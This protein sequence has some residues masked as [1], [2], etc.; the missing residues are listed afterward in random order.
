MAKRSI[1]RDFY[2][3]YAAAVGY[4]V[5]R[6]EPTLALDCMD[7]DG[8]TLADLVRARVDR[9]DLGVIRKAWHKD[10]RKP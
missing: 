5:R 8:V 3:G 6:D 7:G 1:A 4:L 10:G 2:A 9:F